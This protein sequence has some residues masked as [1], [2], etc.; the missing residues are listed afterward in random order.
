MMC[1]SKRSTVS[2]KCPRS[3]TNVTVVITGHRPLITRNRSKISF[4]CLANTP[5]FAS[6]SAQPFVDSV[7]VLPASKSHSAMR[8]LG[9]RY[10]NGGLAKQLK[11]ERPWLEEVRK[12]LLD[13]ADKADPV[14]ATRIKQITAW[15]IAKVL[16]DIEAAERE[17][18]AAEASRA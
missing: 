4:E 18:A 13:E 2:T 9:D 16:K 14:K 5:V 12:L 11:A 10:N 17:R 7:F 3:R 1:R 6:I 15:T 8:A